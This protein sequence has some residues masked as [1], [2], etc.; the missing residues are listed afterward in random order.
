[1]DVGK[2]SLKKIIGLK[3]IHIGSLTLNSNILVLGSLGTCLSRQ[4]LGFQ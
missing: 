3:I 4:T 1:M 2:E